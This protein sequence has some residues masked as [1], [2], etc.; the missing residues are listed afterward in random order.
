MPG[1]VAMIFGR[2]KK[3]DIEEGATYRRI[4]P[5]QV[6]ETAKVD[7][8]APNR[9]GIPHVTYRVRFEAPSGSL[10]GN[11]DKRVLALETFETH[12]KGCRVA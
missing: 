10:A 5:S 6:I 3:Q 1:D 9:F 8:V 11:T 4:L 7:L 12:Y 2:A